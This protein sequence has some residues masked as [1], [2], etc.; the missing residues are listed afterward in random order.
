MNLSKADPEE[1]PKLWE[2]IPL[3]KYSRPSKPLEESIRLGFHNFIQKFI[4]PSESNFDLIKKISLTAIPKRSLDRIVPDINY[5][6]ATEE[7]NTEILKYLD[8]DLTENNIIFFVGTPFSGK[9]DILTKLS[10]TNT[11]NIIADPTPDQI[12]SLDQNFIDTVLEKF[13]KPSVIINF[14]KWFFKHSDGFNLIKTILNIFWSNPCKIVIGVDS[15]TWSYLIYAIQIDSYGK[16][17]L[18]YRPFEAERLQIFLDQ[19]AHQKMKREIVFR[20]S[21][22]GNYII[23]PNIDTSRGKKKRKFVDNYL[24]N[25]AG[26][27]NGIPLLAWSIWRN[28]LRKVPDD[29]F[30]EKNLDEDE[31]EEISKMNKTSQILWVLPWNKMNFPLLPDVLRRTDLIILN[32]ILIHKEIMEDLLFYLLP[33]NKEEILKSV[34]ILVKY[35]LI[36]K[37]EK[38]WKIT[39]LSYPKIRERLNSEG[40]LVDEF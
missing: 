35:G 3:N 38:I 16:K 20:D 32:T 10:L 31:S 2:I 12:F 19:L 37:H 33:L 26:Y 4:K 24:R 11:W 28:S 13:K 40:F 7:L 14:E 8:P 34:S 39:V 6:K 29:E 15:W 17:A 36:E 21:K 1:E 23:K 9:E 30:L 25:L 27:S 22:T 5:S 18:S